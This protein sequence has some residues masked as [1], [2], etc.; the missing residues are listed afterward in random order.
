MIDNVIHCIHA[1]QR[2]MIQKAG[3]LTFIKSVITARPIHQLL[4]AEAPAWVREEIV[5]W[6][7]A[8]FWA[9]KK[10]VHGGQC[11]VSWDAV[12]KPTRLG[13][14]GVK[15]LKL[16]GLALRVRWMWLRRTDPSRPWQGLP[17]LSD[18]EVDNVFQSLAKFQIGDWRKTFFWK[19][20][21]VNGQSAEEIAP[22][23]TGLVPTRRKNIR[24]VA[25]ALHGDTWI[26]DI[27]G[28]MS[29]EVWAQCIKL[30]QEINR[31]EKDPTRPDCIT[32]KGSV[33][34]KYSAK[35]TYGM[36]CQGEHQLEY[37]PTHLEILRTPILQKFW[38]A[39]HSEEAVDLR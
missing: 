18:P 29:S 19:D 9:G 27:N 3:R 13:G 22:E 38:L 39:G 20:R 21:W 37:G 30:W 11:L 2:S 36:L 28:D 23:A 4:V 35:A 24:C 12:A 15:D 8:F 26:A 34:G 32:W 6:I 7:R 33:D 16:Q 5:K 14:L 1:W 10:E 17:S 25:D 31:V